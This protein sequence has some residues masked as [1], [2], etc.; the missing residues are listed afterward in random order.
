MLE[1]IEGFN[2]PIVA[3]RGVGTVTGDDYRTVLAPAV[4]RATAGGAKARLLL[5]LGEGFEGYDAG[6]MA[7]DAGFGVTHLGSFDRMAV[8]TDEEWLRRAVH[9][10]GGLI[11]GE[12]RLF[13][14]AEAADARAWITG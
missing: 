2:D 5:E 12:V 3:L 11:P 13:T 14:V 1:P 9:L 6:G 10:F 4:S 8:V 7:A